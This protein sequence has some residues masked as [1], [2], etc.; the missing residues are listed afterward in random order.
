MDK[1]ICCDIGNKNYKIGIFLRGKIKKTYKI[2]RNQG[3]KKI[4]ELKN[5]LNNPPSFF[6][7]VVPEEKEKLEKKENVYFLHKKQFKEIKGTYP[8]IGID[9][10]LGMY[11]AIKFYN[12]DAI[13]IDYGTA[14]T[15][16]VIAKNGKFLGGIII[17]SFNIMLHSLWIKTALIKNIS[18]SKKIPFLGKSTSQCIT[19]GIKEIVVLGIKTKVEHIYKKFGKNFSIILTGEVPKEI[20]SIFPDSVYNENLILKGIYEKA[21]NLYNKIP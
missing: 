12:K 19:T 14:I 7:S 4:I 8:G 1:C 16:D 21:R 11:S 5:K 10:I 20:L 18:F 15:I 13:V 17:P 2:P 3:I 9:R 6:I